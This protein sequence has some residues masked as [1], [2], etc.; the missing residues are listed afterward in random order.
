MHHLTQVGIL[1]LLCRY[2]EDCAAYKWGL[3]S[4]GEIVQKVRHRRD[5]YLVDVVLQAVE[6]G[7]SSVPFNHHTA[8]NRGLQTIADLD[9]LSAALQCLD[10]FTYVAVRYL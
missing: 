5:S 1:L 7:V 10:D 3:T 8:L 9:A 2:I 4:S 6:D